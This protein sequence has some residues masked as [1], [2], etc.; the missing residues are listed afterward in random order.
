MKRSR[1]RNRRTKPRP[2]KDFILYAR[3]AEANPC[4]EFARWLGIT[5]ELR[6]G[7]YVR[8]EVGVGYWLDEY[9]RYKDG[10]G[11]SLE[12]HHLWSLA[13]R[14]DLTSNLIRLTDDEHK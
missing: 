8:L 9:Q 10:R 5:Y 13:R 6:C 4:S 7:K 12:R 2:P 11:V 14:P 1:L 3:Y